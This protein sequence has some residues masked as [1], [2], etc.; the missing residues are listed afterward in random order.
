MEHGW[1]EAG[2]N[3]GD[4]TSHPWCGRGRCLGRIV[5]EV[6]HLR[7]LRRLRALFAGG[8]EPCII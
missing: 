4:R 2:L 7:T 1:C 8:Y 3:M 5:L 6:E